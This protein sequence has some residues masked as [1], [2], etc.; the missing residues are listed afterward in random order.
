MPTISVF[1]LLWTLGT[2]TPLPFKQ[3]RARE[4]TTSTRET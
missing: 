1:P 2:L 3:H 4:V